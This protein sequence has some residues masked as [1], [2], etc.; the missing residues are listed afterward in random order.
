M[1]AFDEETFG[2]VAALVRARDVDEA[3]RLANHSAYGLGA[4]IWSMAVFPS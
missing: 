4:S 3:V 2:P 1:A